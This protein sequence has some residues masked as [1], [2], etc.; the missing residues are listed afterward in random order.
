MRLAL[1]LL[2]SLAALT[3]IALACLAVSAHWHQDDLLAMDLEAEGRMAATLRAVV[4]RICDLAGPDAVR[5]VVQTINTNSPRNVRWLRPDEV[6]QMPGRDLPAEVDARMETGEPV[7]VHWPDEK[8]GEPVRYLYIPVADH[9]KKLGVVEAS[10]SMAPRAAFVKRGHIQTAAVGFVVLGLS[11]ALAVILGRRLIGRPID[12]ITMTVRSFG[13]GHYVPPTVP[14]GR[15]E[16][17]TL[18]TELTVLGERLAERERMRHDDRLRTVG[19]LASGVAHELGTPLSVVSVRARLIAS[20]EATGAEAIA[21][22]NAILEQSERMTRLVRQLLDYSRRSAGVPTTVDLRHAALQAVEMLEPLAK[23]RGVTLIAASEANGPLE[24]RGDA[25]QLQ[26]V[27]TNLVLNGVQAMSAGGR[28]EIAS[29]REP[30]GPGPRGRNGERCWIRVTDEGP[31]IAADELS[32]L[33]EPFYTT[34]PAGEGTGLGL[35]VA[36]AIVEEHGGSIAVRSD[37]GHGAVFT[38]YL[39]TAAPADARMAS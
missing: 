3:L 5:D 34:K 20:G 6:P 21:N 14:A 38:V 4:I 32:H 37:P 30:S 12:A 15:D 26:Q 11:G 17:G 23:A 19:Q 18:A 7:W 27:L 29:G 16:L 36:Q 8:T 28:L 33:F 13:N 10:E 25:A 1:K 31:G 35:A 9:G 22:A 39:P 24:V 2:S